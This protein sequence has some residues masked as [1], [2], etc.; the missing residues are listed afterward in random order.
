MMKHYNADDKGYAVL[1]VVIIINAAALVIVTSIMI[2]G[3][4]FHK[5]SL[6]NQKSSQARNIADACAEIALMDIWGNQNISGSYS[7]SIGEGSC[8][9]S[10]SGTSPNKNIQ[11]EAIV[12]D[13][14]RRLEVDIDQVNP[15]INISSWQEVADF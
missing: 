2:W 5:T 14:H 7:A 8:T 4:Y 15:D 11:V 12:D 1:F 10:I 6:V 9:Y 13:I 3:F